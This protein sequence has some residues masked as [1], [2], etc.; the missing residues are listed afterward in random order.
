LRLTL[1][2]FQAI[3]TGQLVQTPDQVQAFKVNVH[4]AFFVPAEREIFGFAL[5]P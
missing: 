2:V 3:T 5:P 1:F 4:A